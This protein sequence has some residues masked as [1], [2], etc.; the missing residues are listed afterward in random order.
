MKARIGIVAVSLSVVVGVALL[1]RG[2]SFHDVP[3]TV[4]NAPIR[5]Y[6]I[7]SHGPAIPTMAPGSS[8][9]RWMLT[10]DEQS[11]PVT[12]IKVWAGQGNYGSLPLLGQIAAQPGDRIQLD[13]TNAG[14]DHH[15]VSIRQDPLAPG[16]ARAP[17]WLENDYFAFEQQM[18]VPYHLKLNA[19]NDPK[20][21]LNSVQVNDTRICVRTRQG[22]T[23]GSP[24]GFTNNNSWKVQIK[25]CY[26]SDCAQDPQE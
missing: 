6:R 22:G 21:T 11:L 18:G 10:N 26:S 8:G 16:A 5:I 25:I 15:I 3:E 14:A 20:Y 23:P 13:F 17:I 24:C 9:T 4:D 1:A 12:G 7:G 19:A 2:Q